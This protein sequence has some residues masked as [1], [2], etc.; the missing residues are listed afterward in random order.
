[1]DQQGGEFLSFFSIA[2]YEAAIAAAPPGTLIKLGDLEKNIVTCTTCG[3]K[4]DRK[5]AEFHK[6]P[7]K[8]DACGVTYDENLTKH[9]PIHATAHRGAGTVTFT[10]GCQEEAL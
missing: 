3:S 4:M 1:M 10:A 7:K 2:D 5:A 9:T 8:C 6:H